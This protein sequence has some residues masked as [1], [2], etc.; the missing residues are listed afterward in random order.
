MIEATLAEYGIQAEVSG[1]AKHIYSIYNKMEARQLNFEEINDL[2]GAR[3]IVDTI[4]ECYDVEAI[5]HEH[6]PPITAF[7]DGHVGRDWI[8]SPKENQY[9][10]L[11]TTIKIDTKIIEVQIR[12]LEMHQVAEFGAAA[13]HWRYKDFRTYRK[14]KTPKVMKA[15][16]VNW[17]KQL[18]ELRE[19][20]SNLQEAST[21]IHKDLLKDRIYVITPK[22]HVI[23][24]P[25]GA[26]PLDFAYRIHTDFGHR[27]AGARVGGHIV[28]LDYTLKN[29]EIVELITARARSGPNP[30]W[31][32]VSKDEEG[33][34]TYLFARTPLARS[35]IQNWLNK[36]N[37][38]Q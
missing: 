35:K 26:A 11:H 2:L 36:H 34:S 7:Y 13:E 19:N 3:I 37:S 27:F 22:G 5:I 29:G 30:D 33:K 31:L 10:S 12:T 21:L 18:A 28:R 20:L 17:G 8:A 16:D 15:K 1:R 4:E 6:W 9:Q 23:D 32:A 14:G 38:K 25:R 24:L